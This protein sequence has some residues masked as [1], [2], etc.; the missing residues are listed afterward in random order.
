MK[1]SFKVLFSVVLAMV[2]LLSAVPVFAAEEGVWTEVASLINGRY[3]HQMEIIDGEIYA[4]G[5]TEYGVGYRTS[6]EVYNP[7]IDT[8][9]SVANMNIPRSQFQTEV[10]NGKIYA[11]G[12]DS[13]A[14]VYDPQLNLWTEVTSL[15]HSRIR[16][17]TEVI[18]GKIYAVGGDFLTSAEVYDPQLNIWTELASMRRDRYLFKTEVIDGEIYAVGGRSNGVEIPHVEVYN[19]QTDTW[20]EV[21]NMNQARM[22]HQTE[23]IDGKLYAIGGRTQ[24]GLKISSVEVYD[25]QLNTWTELKNMITGRS[26]FK[27]EVLN[28]KLYVIGGINQEN[29]KILNVEMYDPEFNTWTELDSLIVE[30]SGFQTEVIDGKIYVAGGFNNG[31]LFNVEA[32]LISSLDTP[33]N[34]TAEVGDSQVTLSWDEVEN[35]EYYILKRSTTSGGPYE[36]IDNEIFDS[37]LVDMNVENGTTYYYVVSAVNAVGESENSNEASVTPES[38]VEEINNRAILVIVM[39]NG[40]EKEYDITMNEVEDFI[41]W[42]QSNLSVAYAIEKTGNMG[43][44]LNRK[45]YIIHDNI[46]TFEVNEKTILA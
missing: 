36:V 37:T 6:V 23:V 35:A 31:S 28:G 10:L 38:T 26:Y 1:K 15:N 5:G 20:S 8:W 40:L 27:T 3:D 24:E 2:M 12:G 46:L 45:D 19:P 17:Q 9:E 13:T 22:D 4:I 16:H 18:D 44:F 29:V 7:Q 42:Y 33:I 39:E 34:L 14:E 32:I 21:A 25:P 11:L 30:R 43:P 41:N